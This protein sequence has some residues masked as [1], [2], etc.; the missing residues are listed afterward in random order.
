MLFFGRLPSLC[1]DWPCFLTVL[2]RGGWPECPYLVL[3][4]GGW[5]PCFLDCSVSRRLTTL[6]LPSLAA[7]RLTTLS[8]PSLAARRLH[9]LSLPSLAARR[10]HALSDLPFFTWRLP[11]STCTR[12]CKTFFLCSMF[13]CKTRPVDCCIRKSVLRN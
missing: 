8:L 4:P 11:C 6:S 2:L 12:C 1:C 3:L 10:L 9:A 7:R 5:L 13:R